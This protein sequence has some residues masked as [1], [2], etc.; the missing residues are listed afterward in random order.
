VDVKVLKMSLASAALVSSL[1]AG[2]ALWQTAASAATE[3][4][5]RQVAAIDS[6]ARTSLSLHATPGLII[7]VIR[8]GQIV[9]N[10]GFGYRDV[11]RKLAPTDDTR[12][13][14]GS[15]TKQ[16]TAAS[17]LLLRDRGKVNIDKPL[18]T[19]LPQIPHA[20]G[21]TIR[22][23]LSM[24]GGYAEFSEIANFGEMVKHPTTAA[25]VVSTVVGRPLDFKP[26]SRY[27]YSNTGYMLLQMVIEH[28]SGV[29]YGR[30]LQEHIFAPLGM[31]ATYLRGA[32]D[33]TANVA[34]EYTSFALGPWELFDE[35]NYTWIG[36]A[37]GIIS[38]VADLAKWN[39]GFDSGKLISAES[40]KDMT[41]AGTVDGKPNPAGYGFGL[42]VAH[43]PNGHRVFWHGGNT[44]GTATQDARF[45]DDHLGIIVLANTGV[46]DYNTVVRAIYDL[47]V[48]EKAVATTSGES[49]PPAPQN[50]ADP[51]RLKEATSWL[52]DAIAG[53]IDDGGLR[54]D[55]RK[56]MTPAHRASLKAL[57]K[58]GSR[59]Y[60]FIGSDRRLPTTSYIFKVTA[61]ERTFV[62]LYSRDDGGTVS[63]VLIFPFLAF[64]NLVEPVPEP[65][66]PA[67]PEL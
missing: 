47:M 44:Q 38:D 4:D 11:A 59:T 52:N 39:A 25:H 34:A 1:M 64:P 48:P 29:P 26:G 60:E 20:G 12:C 50:T 15:N 17:I 63:N 24:T 46:Y 40:F 22:Q 51:E 10:K 3:L 36:G 67:A 5:A 66:P 43:M 31:H 37:G 23:L 55:F 2:V 19:Y 33:T 45:P 62:Y 7:A 42:T 65:A 57:A 35:W 56:L 9:Y 49:P 6:I 41:T 54:T 32:T 14:I 18:S 8:D 27:S 28:V 13:P 30:F 58:F 61:P 21:V 53:R 16:F